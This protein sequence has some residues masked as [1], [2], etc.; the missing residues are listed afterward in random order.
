MMDSG[1][2][3]IWKSSC[4]WV[5]PPWQAQVCPGECHDYDDDDEE[6]VYV[7]DDNDDVYGDVANDDDYDHNQD[8]YQDHDDDDDKQGSRLSLH[9]SRNS[10]P[11]YKSPALIPEVL[12]I[13]MMIM[14]LMLMIINRWW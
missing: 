9:G 14:M 3:R 2:E 10:L 13:N 12:I 7:Y 8:Q 6:V 5:A 11:G 1:G 4:P